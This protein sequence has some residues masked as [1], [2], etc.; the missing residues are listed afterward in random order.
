MKLCTRLLFR[1][2]FAASILSTWLVSQSATAQENRCAVD[3]SVPTGDQSLTDKLD[4]C[5]S[6]LVPPKVGDSEI[7]EPP[8]ETGTIKVIPPGAIPEQQSGA[9]TPT[10]PDGTTAGTSDDPGYNL[11]EL[12]DAMSR[13]SAIADELKSMEARKIEV[14]DIS[15]LLGG[16]NAAVLDTSLA[17]HASGIDALRSTISNSATLAAAVTAAGLTVAGIVAAKIDEPQTVT[18][19]GR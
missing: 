6:V 5:N 1:A 14:R 13:S 4:N 10:A 19:F 9:G 12:I 16:A 2:L 18:L 11:S 3:P 8:P 17:E 7:V 15:I